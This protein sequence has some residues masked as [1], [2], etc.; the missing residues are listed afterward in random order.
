MVDVAGFREAVN[1]LDEE[2]VL[3]R[4]ISVFGNRRLSDDVEPFYQV[5]QL[6]RHALPVII[7]SGDAH[8]AVVD[9]RMVE[10]QLLCSSGK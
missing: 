3:N 10:L 4:H 5:H 6:Q 1:V 7:G 2:L 8:K 9:V